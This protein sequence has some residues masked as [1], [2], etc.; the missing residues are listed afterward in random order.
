MSQSLNPWSADDEQEHYPSVLEWWCTEGFISDINKKNIWS[1]K[2]SFTEWC[3]M[4]KH[5]GSTY[6]FTLFDLNKRTHFSQYLRDDTKKLE[7]KN[8][9]Y[10]IIKTSYGSSYLT[11]RYPKYSIRYENTDH[12][13]LL[14]LDYQ[15]QAYPHWIT[16]DITGGYLPMGLGFY[17]YGFIPRNTIQGTLTIQDESFPV[18]GTGYYEHV[19]GDFSYKNPSSNM[20]FLKK[21]LSI[22]QK[23]IGWWIYHH[24]PRIPDNLKFYSENNPLGY[25]WVWGVLDNGW[26]FFLGNIL[27]WIAEGPIFGTLILTKDG[28]HYKEFCDVSYSYTS[29]Q[30]SEHYDF[31]FPTGIDI[32]ARNNQEKITFPCEMH[33]I[34][35]ALIATLHQ[36]KWIAFVICEAP[37]TV[38]GTYTQS[39]QHLLLSGD[40]KIEPQRQVS[41]NGHNEIALKFVKPPKGVGI[42]VLFDSEYLK[43]YLDASLIFTPIPK[44]KVIMKKKYQ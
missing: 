31:V 23:L 6:D 39:D 1:F 43:K 14:E 19:W 13:I 3:T 18:N 2:G 22:Y 21:S 26:S 42:Q 8:D 17:R 36:K 9:K 20:S 41:R 34:A 4:E 44:W 15:S 32:V 28:K 27:F 11:G 12:D 38:R 29:I 7:V 5:H 10:G 37:G 24:Q 25:D 30:R 40:C 16:Q 33:M 35:R